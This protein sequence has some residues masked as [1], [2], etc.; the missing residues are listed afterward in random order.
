MRLEGLCAPASEG[1]SEELLFVPGDLRGEG[2]R[3]LLCCLLKSAVG[4]I[5]AD[6]GRR[7]RQRAAAAAGSGG[8]RGPGTRGQGHEWVPGTRGEAHPK[9]AGREVWKLICWPWGSICRYCK[10]MEARRAETAPPRVSHKL[11]QVLTL[12]CRFLLNQRIQLRC[13]LGSSVHF[14]KLG[15]SR[16]SG[17]HEVGA[18]A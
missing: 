2:G 15:K 6:P 17:E 16:F 11:A 5:G 18:G 1:G 12:Q 9:A 4:G 8:G 7:P 14:E 10:G 3:G 13:N